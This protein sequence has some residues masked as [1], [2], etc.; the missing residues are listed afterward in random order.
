MFYSFILK[1]H[2]EEKTILEKEILCNL[3]FPIDK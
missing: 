2:M 3:H 1:L